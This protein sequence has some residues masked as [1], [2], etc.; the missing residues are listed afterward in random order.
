VGYLLGDKLVVGISGRALFDL[1]EEHDVYTKQG[2]EAYRKLQKERG[3]LPLKPGTGFPLVQGLLSIN[4][5]LEHRAI[6]VVVISRNDGDSG[7]RLMNSIAEYGLDITRA[8]FCGGRDAA[9]YFEAYECKLFLSAEAGDVGN[10]LANGGA[11]ALV[12]PLPAGF[13]YDP[14]EVRIAFDADAVIF[15]D[16]AERIYQ[17]KGMAEFMKSETDNA[18]VP[19]QPGPFKPFLQSLANIQSR[20]KPEECP[21]RTALVTAR[22]APAHERAIRTL[23]GWRIVVNEMHFLGGIEKTGVLQVFKP[24]IFFDDQQSHVISCSKKLPAAQVCY[25]DQPM[26]KPA[27]RAKLDENTLPAAGE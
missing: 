26:K 5:K 2:L 21:I 17:E 20:F 7:L 25:G 10:V 14:G 23:Q 18:R 24:N 22:N 6:E 8:S 9:K 27:Q 16:E 1:S 13:E 3:N 15:S 12:F 4:A 11:A 19:L